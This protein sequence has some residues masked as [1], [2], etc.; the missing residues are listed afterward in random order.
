M[1]H[2]IPV[3]CLCACIALTLLLCSCDEEKNEVLMRVEDG[4]MLR[5]ST[6][7]VRDTRP[8]PQ[9]QKIKPLSQERLQELEARLGAKASASDGNTGISSF[10]R[11]IGGI[12]P[13]E[14]DGSICFYEFT[15][16]FGRITCY[17]ERIWGGDDLATDLEADFKAAEHA[18]GLLS[19]WI[20]TSAMAGTAESDKAKVGQFINGQFL[21]GIKNFILYKRS[22]PGEE[23]RTARFAL[24]MMERLKFDAERIKAISGELAERIAADKARRG[25]KAGEDETAVF[26]LF[27][28]VLIEYGLDSSPEL[29]SFLRAHPMEAKSAEFAG[30]VFGHEKSKPVVES[31]KKRSDKEKPDLFIVL[32]GGRKIELVELELFG[33]RNPRTF[34]FTLVIP[35]GLANDDILTNGKLDGGAGKIEWSCSREDRHSLGSPFAYAFWIEMDEGFQQRHFGGT[36]LQKD[37]FPQYLFF[38]LGLSPEEMKE[39]EV[40]F[41]KIQPSDNPAE[42]IL[43]NISWPQEKIER[44]CLEDAL[45]LFDQF[46]P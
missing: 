26:L 29:A 41:E 37:E 17:L 28:S 36:I 35:Q 10:K 39:L 46:H 6:L 32:F 3:T 42:F 9:G 12:S 5:E 16:Q 8:G 23:A 25:E 1:K 45:K 21:L 30:F 38:T 44:R 22:Y 15:N 4:R 11:K 34:T 18:C 14:Y 19:E 7:C 13:N 43:K 33:P 20:A 40:L 2:T 24:Y 27:T 31:L